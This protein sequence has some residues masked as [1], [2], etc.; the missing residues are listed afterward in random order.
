MIRRISIACRIRGKA[1][2]RCTF[3][4]SSCT[5]GQDGSAFS[6]PYWH[7]MQAEAFGILSVPV[8]DGQKA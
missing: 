6:L 1:A 4:L 2:R 7:L 5:E 8:D 3:D